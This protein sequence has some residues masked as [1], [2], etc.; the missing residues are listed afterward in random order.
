MFFKFDTLHLLKIKVH[1][2][3]PELALLGQFLG[4]K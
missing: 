4:E 3:V 2:Y 1:K